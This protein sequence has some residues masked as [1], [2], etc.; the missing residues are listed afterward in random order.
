MFGLGV[1]PTPVALQWGGASL[2][3]AWM[4]QQRPTFGAV[5]RDRAAVAAA[6][7]VEAADLAET[8]PQVIS[9]GIPFLIVPLR[10]RAA[11]DR[12]IPDTRAIERFWQTAG[13]PVTPIFFFS[14]ERGADEATAYSRMFA[15]G[16]GIMEDPATGGAS[17]P[18]GCYLLRN[19]LVTPAQ[20][21][22][23][24]SV[25]GVVMGRPSRIHVAIESDGTEITAVRVGGTAVLLAEG[26]LQ[27]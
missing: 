27:V 24:V 6:L 8:P 25:Q 11:V 15:P 3:F 9:C 22:T 19:A 17:G 1:G 16:F 18:L 7:N 12:A 10:T 26:T 14:R 23:I 2:T 20:A 4:T 13:L 21:G 5:M